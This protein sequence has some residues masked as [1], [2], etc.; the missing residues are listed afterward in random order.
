[1]Q[2]LKNMGVLLGIFKN[3]P[4]DEQKTN[5]STNSIYVQ[6]DLVD[7]TPCYN[8]RSI[9]ENFD[10]KLIVIKDHNIDKDTIKALFPEDKDN[11]YFVDGTEKKK[12]A[13]YRILKTT[14]DLN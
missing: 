10:A 14:D 4:T 11:T 9:I 2:S 8:L 7:K 3:S 1:M 5:Q 12:D 6:N 13:K